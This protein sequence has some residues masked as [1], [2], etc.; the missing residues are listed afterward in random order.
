MKNA[1][2]THASAC[3]PERSEGSLL[4]RREEILRCA[5]DDGLKPSIPFSKQYREREQEPFPA[6]FSG[7]ATHSTVG[8]R[9]T[10]LSERLS[11]VAGWAT[12][13]LL[14]LLWA[15]GCNSLPP[16]PAGAAATR[17]ALTFPRSGEAYLLRGWRGLWSEGID[18]L[19]DELRGAGVDAEV[20]RADQAGELGD[21]LVDRFSKRGRHVP[22]VLIGFSYGADDAVLVAAKLARAGIRLD[23][24]LT[25]DP[26]T[27]PAVP[28]NVKLCRNYYQSNGPLDLFPWLRGIP[29]EPAERF[30]PAGRLV[31][32]N[33]RD[34]PDLL[35]PGTS[36]ATIAGN[37]QLHRV[38]VEEVLRVCPVMFSGP[39]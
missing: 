32:V 3:H 35:E 19:G 26:V 16:G 17:P 38:V 8:G 31:N 2:H 9:Q 28:G 27:P 22:L 37:E 10:G 20:F 33:I 34:R 29:L 4:P 23:L 36:H 11:S 12:A 14:L 7:N 15:A 13:L 5:Q 24:L 18:R 6:S 21:A 30:G 25:I 39:P 1:N